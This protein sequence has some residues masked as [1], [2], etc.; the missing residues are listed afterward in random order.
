MLTEG[1]IEALDWY[2]RIY[3]TI[4]PLHLR[5][6]VAD[7]KLEKLTTLSNQIYVFI[8]WLLFHSFALITGFSIFILFTS[9][10]AVPI[11]QIL[12]LAAYVIG[13]IAAWFPSHI[14]AL[15][16]DAS[17]EILNAL[18]SIERF[19]QSKITKLS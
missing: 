8:C 7:K 10:E 9:P 5:F 3:S 4:T 18:F 1:Q 15:T 11:F 2:F 12:F 16:P 6:N 14:L 17:L 19:V 13:Y